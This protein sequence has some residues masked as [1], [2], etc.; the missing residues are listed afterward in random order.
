MSEEVLGAKK[1]IEAWKK[2][3]FLSLVAFLGSG[4]FLVDNLFILANFNKTTAKVVKSETIRLPGSGSTRTYYLTVRFTNSKGDKVTK[5]TSYGSSM[6]NYS[7]GDE[8]AIYYRPGK[9]HDFYVGSFMT[10]WAAPL[11]GLAL[12]FFVL[13]GARVLKDS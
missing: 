13:W 1:K 9:A 5:K 8:V 7:S 4:Y 10:M 6:F 12:A 11:T 3:L 2:V